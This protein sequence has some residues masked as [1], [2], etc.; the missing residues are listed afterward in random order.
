MGNHR[1]M[2]AYTVQ[3]LRE[4]SDDAVIAAHDEQGSGVNASY[5]LDELRRREAKRAEDASYE[6]ARSSHALAARAYELARRTYWLSIAAVV[7]AATSTIAA[8]VGIGV[9]IGVASRKSV[10]R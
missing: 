6:L 7:F 9:A 5:F 4:M 10:P 2:R 8:I 3:V 1:D